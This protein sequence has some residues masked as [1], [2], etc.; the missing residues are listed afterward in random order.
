MAALIADFVAVVVASFVI[1]LVAVFTSEVL[2]MGMGGVLFFF[3]GVSA[4]W[5]TS[6]LSH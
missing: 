1:D 3:A 5:L 2:R 6:S 4:D